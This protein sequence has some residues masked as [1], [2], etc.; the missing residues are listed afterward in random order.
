MCPSEDSK[1]EN[2]YGL[3]RPQGLVNLKEGQ[4]YTSKTG[5]SRLQ[6]LVN[7]KEGQKQT[8]K[9]GISHHRERTN[10]LIDH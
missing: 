9:T 5:L 10:A 8:S 4:K 7:L 1:E 6:G 3:S 2:P